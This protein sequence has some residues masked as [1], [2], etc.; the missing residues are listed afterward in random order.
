MNV[1]AWLIVILPLA[2]VLGM[3]FYS[4]RYV[5]DITD[6]L[7]SGRVAGRYVL[8]V[9]DL[10][11]GLSVISFVGMVQQNYLTGMA[12]GFWGAVAAPVGLFM[13]LSGY[14][15]YRFRQTRCLSC[16]QFLEVR[17]SRSFRIVACSIRTIAEMGTNAIG[18]A[19]AVQ[20]FI[21]F[22]G[23]RPHIHILGLN[24]P[25]YGILVAFLLT[26]AL[27]MILPA[28]RI[29]L[30]IADCLQGIIS[31]PIF[32]IFTVFVLL[33]ISWFKD[34]A[35][36]MLDRPAGQSFLNPMDIAQLRDF[37][38]FALIVN[39]VGSVLNRAAWIGNDVTTSGRT[40]HEQKMANILGTWRNGFAWT[41]LTLIA[42]FV[43]TFM[44]GSRFSGEARDVRVKLTDRIAADIV[45]NPH[46][47]GAIRAAV[48]QIPPAQHHI[49]VD[50]P[51]SRDQN[52][53]TPYLQ[54]IRKAILA[55][56]P[57]SG[58]GNA[59]FQQFKSLYTQQLMPVLLGSLFSPV[60][61]GLFTLLM[62]MMLLSSDASR[63]FNSAGTIIQDVVLPLRKKP[64]SVEGHLKLLKVC[65]LGVTLLFFIVSLFFTQLDFINMFLTIMCA[66]WLGAA[67]PIMIGGLYTRFGTTTGAWGALVVGSGIPTAGLLCERNWPGLIYPWLAR[68]HWVGPV[69]HFLT[70]VSRPFNPYIEWKMDAVK[71]PI[72]SFEI[73]FLAMLFGVI[74]Y[75]VGSLVTLKTPFNLD[76]MLHRGIYSDEQTPKPV[77]QRLTLRRL[78]QMIV[79]I[80]HEYT[81]GDKIIAWSVVG[82]GL[83]YGFGIMFCGVVLWNVISPWPA[84]YWA[85]YFFITTIV[86]ALAVGSVSTVWFLIGGIRDTFALMR[87]LAARVANP[88][89]NGRVE[90]HVSTVDIA[91]FQE[92]EQQLQHPDEAT[93]SDDSNEEEKVSV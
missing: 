58:A 34:V 9:G 64:L 41:M 47:R 3:A 65:T 30:L 51:Y 18:P 73:Y 1:L 48:A 82:W 68:H 5:R 66:V 90:G 70:A 52:P 8:S 85:V 29:S 69:G 45:Q 42:I 50:A 10:A 12:I 80:D 67:G 2:F 25:T 16:G 15:V 38:L 17:Y 93:T 74:T 89:D 4:R 86:T 35:P 54:N 92:I 61:L 60:L 7:A 83:I 19:V 40:P 23:I 81:L 46:T 78:I 49:G 11:S 75:V 13:A 26:C 28:G 79:G 27:V 55:N 21:Y 31:Y 14:C 43:I 39:I 32:V 44:L 72:N 62:I 71:F 84:R 33:N 53:D 59:L 91:R 63:T 36:V 6:Y 87:D 76:R 57:D 88:L 22:L 20:F 37:N 24:V 77:K 56:S